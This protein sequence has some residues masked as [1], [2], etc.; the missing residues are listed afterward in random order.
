MFVDWVSILNQHCQKNRINVP[1]Y[2]EASNPHGGFGS[3][4]VVGSEKFFSDE[5]CEKKKSAK[6]SAARV[7]LTGMNVVVCKYYAQI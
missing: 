5:Y 6:Q 4:V 1:K 3:C 7:A 2:S